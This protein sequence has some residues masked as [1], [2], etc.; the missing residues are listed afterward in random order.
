MENENLVQPNRSKQIESVKFDE[1][2]FSNDPCSAWYHFKR[3][4]DKCS[5]K[6]IHCDKVIKAYQG[7]TTGLREH[8]RRK[9][10]IDMSKTKSKQTGTL[11]L[12]VI[13]CLELFI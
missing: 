7:T 2:V 13:I 12:F 5:G 9:H 6:C 11:C 3:G 8:L 10:D 4:S 1:D